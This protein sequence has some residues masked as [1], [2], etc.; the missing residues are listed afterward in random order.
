MPRVLEASFD[1]CRAR[2]CVADMDD[3]RTNYAAGVTLG[4]DWSRGWCS[5]ARLRMQWEKTEERWNGPL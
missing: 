3:A 5:G 1:S 4:C 2:S